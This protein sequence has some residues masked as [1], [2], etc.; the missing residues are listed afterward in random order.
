MV[1]INFRYHI[2]VME[3]KLLHC[4]P[5]II[6]INHYHK[7]NNFCTVICYMKENPFL[8]KYLSRLATILILLA[9][10][11]ATNHCFSASKGKSLM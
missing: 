5:H 2:D 4:S 7:S 10:V 1:E 3:I 9:I 11:T 6:R 8:T